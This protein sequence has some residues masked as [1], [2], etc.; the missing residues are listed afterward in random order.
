MPSLRRPGWETWAS[1]A[2]IT[3]PPRPCVQGNIVQKVQEA[4][5]T[6]DLEVG[7][8]EC[9]V[10]PRRAAASYLTDPAFCCQP[11]AAAQPRPPANT[12][13]LPSAAPAAPGARQALDSLWGDDGGPHRARVLGGPGGGCA[14]AG[15]PLSCPALP[16]LH[17]MPVGRWRASQ[18]GC[19]H[20]MLCWCF[21]CLFVDAVRLPPPVCRTSGSGR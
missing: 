8:D 12:C 1:K 19:T 13:R 21:P 6:A 7:L 20:S 11:L 2:T 18:L 17:H 14:C 5:A 9:S 16:P 10:L 3:C 15:R 4:A